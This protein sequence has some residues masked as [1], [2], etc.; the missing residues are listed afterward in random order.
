MSFAT[1]HRRGF[2]LVEL[3]LV[4]LLLSLIAGLMAP[5]FSKMLPGAKM[6]AASTEFQAVINKLRADASITMRR[7]RLHF[8]ASERKYW[9]TIETDPLQKPGSFEAPTGALEGDFVLPDDVAFES[10]SG[11]PQ[12]ED[13]GS[14]ITFKADGSTDAA[15]I[16]MGMEDGTRRT[17]TIDAATAKVTVSE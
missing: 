9:V 12:I 5:S 14:A 13:G 15:T 11:V 17:F 6:R 16:V 8:S 1:R 7:Y 3:I 4:M 2:S 10:F